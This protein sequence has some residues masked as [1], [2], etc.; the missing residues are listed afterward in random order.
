MKVKYIAKWITYSKVDLVLCINVSVGH[1]LL[2]HAILNLFHPKVQQ[3]IVCWIR[4]WVILWESA[5]NPNLN[6]ISDNDRHKKTEAIYVFQ[7]VSVSKI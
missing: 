7:S 6:V 2:P 4:F 5:N 1:F 3:Q